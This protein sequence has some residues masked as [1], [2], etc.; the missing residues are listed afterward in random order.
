M[1]REDLYFRLKVFSVHLP[2]LRERIEDQPFLME[3]FIQRRN[4]KHGR[5]I[6]SIDDDC[7]N[8]LAAY[9]SLSLSKPRQSVLDIFGSSEDG[10]V[11]R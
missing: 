4:G 7:L 10:L 9:I 1:L 2:P 11:T 5:R 6:K 3:H 8:A